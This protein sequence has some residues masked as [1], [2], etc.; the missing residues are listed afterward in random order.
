MSNAEFD[1]IVITADDGTPT[2][3]LHLSE[4]DAIELLQFVVTATIAATGHPIALDAM[5]PKRV[6]EIAGELS[7]AIGRRRND[8]P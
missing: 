4:S 5:P 1:A 7:R 6:R 2:Y 3:S 8:R